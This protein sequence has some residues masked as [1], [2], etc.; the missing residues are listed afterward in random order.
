MEIFGN[1][2]PFLNCGKQCL[3]LL[4]LQIIHPPF[5]FFYIFCICPVV[6]LSYL[7][8]ILVLAGKNQTFWRMLKLFKT[9]VCVELLEENFREKLL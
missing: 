3:E 6:L 4:F 9:N 2:S 7:I 8:K 5:S 1:F